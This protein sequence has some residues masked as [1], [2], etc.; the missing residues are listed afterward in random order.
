M[1]QKGYCKHHPISGV[2]ELDFIQN[3]KKF[4][5]KERKSADKAS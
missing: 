3:G 4:G 2:K 5:T 1:E